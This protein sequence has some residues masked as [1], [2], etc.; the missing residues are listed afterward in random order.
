MVQQAYCKNCKLYRVEKPG[1]LQGIIANRDK[2]AV[3]QVKGSCP[4]G[5]E[6]VANDCPEWDIHCG[7]HGPVRMQS[8]GVLVLCRAHLWAV[9]SF[10]F[11]FSFL[12]DNR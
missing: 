1:I 12:F 3:N 8:K 7:C 10:P 2:V 4:K 5:Y 11:P 6:T 9:T